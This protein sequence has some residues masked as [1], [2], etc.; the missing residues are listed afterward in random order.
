MN[1]A[2]AKREFRVSPAGGTYCA[3]RSRKARREIL[4]HQ[5]TL[6]RQ[7]EIPQRGAKLTAYAVSEIAASGSSDRVPQPSGLPNSFTTAG[8]AV[9]SLSTQW[10]IS[11]MA[12]AMN[13]ARAKREFRVSSCAWIDRFV[14]ISHFKCDR[15]DSIEYARI[16]EK[17]DAPESPPLPCP[18]FWRVFIFSLWQAF[19]ST[20]HLKSDTM[21]TMFRGAELC[22]ARAQCESFL[23]HETASEPFSSSCPA[24]CSR[25]FQ[26]AFLHRFRRYGGHAL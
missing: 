25:C 4:P 18:A 12:P 8:T 23:H 3:N 17:S 20:S 15:L 10:I 6:P 19:G 21:Q 5:L 13:F 1:F 9:I 7:S 16:C 2:R 11:L 14:R 26:L 22:S 24:G